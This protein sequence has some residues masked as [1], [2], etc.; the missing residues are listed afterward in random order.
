M[1]RV[2]EF[3]FSNTGGTGIGLYNITR[4]VQKMRGTISA[5]ENIPKGAK[6]TITF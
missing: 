6:F 3:G 5:E 2:F 1:D 4:V